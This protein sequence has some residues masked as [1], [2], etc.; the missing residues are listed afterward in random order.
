MNASLI[1]FTVFAVGALITYPDV[2]LELLALWL[3]IVLVKLV[4]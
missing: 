2:V 3:A 4:R 1:F